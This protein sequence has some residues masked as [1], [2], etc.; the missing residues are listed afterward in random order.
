MSFADLSDRTCAVVQAALSRRCIVC[1][2]KPGNDC[3]SISARTGD[4]NPGGLLPGGRIVHYARTS[5]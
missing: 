5:A 2:A 3:T 1:K 4:P